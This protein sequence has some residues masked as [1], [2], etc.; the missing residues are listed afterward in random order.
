MKK[1]LMVLGIVFVVAVVAVVATCFAAKAKLE[2]IAE[3]ILRDLQA[4]QHEKVYAE[5]APAFRASVTPEAFRA[6]V[7]SRR[8]ALGAY[9]GIRKATG[10]GFSTSSDGPTEGSISLEVDYEK[11]PATGELRFFK[12][13]DAWRLANLKLSFAESL[14]PVP[15]RE[16]LEPLA[17]ELLGLYD[18]SSFVA[19]YS[20]FSEPLKEAWK[21]EAY[22]KDVRGLRSK[23]GRVLASTLRETKD[24][25]GGQVR[26][27]FDVTYEAGAGEGD[28]LFAPGGGEWH[29]LGFR[30]R[31]GGR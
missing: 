10:G 20:R 21:A 26:L 5:A 3:A 19:L 29:L 22:E 4:G 27:V 18:A 25:A 7:E 16:D 6:Y 9:R 23:T 8:K 28:L 2:P 15:A 13:G 12:D 1:V 14:L 11:G 31:V 30:L 24:E 17:R